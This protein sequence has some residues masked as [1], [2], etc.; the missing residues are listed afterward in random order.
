MDT[1][2]SIR[3]LASTNNARG[4][5]FT[6]L[7]KDLFFALGYDDLRL[8]VHKSG[9]EIDIEGTHRLEPRRM[10]AECKARDAKVGGDD[11]NK[12]FGVLTRER[13]RD[14][15]T[16]VSGYFVSL[17]GFRETGREQ[18][19]QTSEHKRAILLDGKR[20][21][22]ELVLSRILISPVEAVERAGRCAAQAMSTDSVLDDVELLGHESGYLWAVYY[23]RYK[24][25]THFALIHAD[26]TALAERVAREVIRADRECT[27]PLRELEYL[28]PPPTGPDRDG[29]ARTSLERYRRWLVAECGYIQLDGLPADADLGALRLKL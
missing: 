11:L 1:P 29:L 6:R 19:L 28:P 26:G 14:E 4:D 16:P 9:R 23:S 22:E 2:S 21:V 8:D 5:L 15:R 27:G 25:R 7:V 13:D 20:V 10:V 3:L 12:F 17:S 18:E 24:R